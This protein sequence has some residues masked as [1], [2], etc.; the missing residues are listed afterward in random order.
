MGIKRWRTEVILSF[1]YQGLS[2][3]HRC[4]FGN[5][6]FFHRRKLLDYDLEILFTDIACFGVENFQNHSMF[7]DGEFA[8][9][10]IR[11]VECFVVSEIP[12][13]DGTLSDFSGGKIRTT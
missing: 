12:E 2:D 1:Y 5:F 6:C 4:R 7:S 3:L 9:Q 11:S 13:V 10:R 8:R